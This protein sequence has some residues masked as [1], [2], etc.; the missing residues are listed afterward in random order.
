MDASKS[1]TISRV[2]QLI[3]NGKIKK[4]LKL[5]YAFLDEQGFQEE[6]NEVLLLQSRL[7]TLEEA[8]YRSGENID[9]GR[10]NI[11]AAVLALLEGI[12][13][14][15]LKQPKPVP[16]YS[17]G[18][19]LHNIPRQM[20]LGDYAECKVRI[21]YHKR[22]L[23]KGFTSTPDT[24][25][26]NISKIGRL[27]E[28]T[29]VP[30]GESAFSVMSVSSK[31][32]QVIFPDIYTEWTFYV[33]PLMPGRHTLILDV[34]LMIEENGEQVRREETFREEIEVSAATT[35]QGYWQTDAY[36]YTNRV[37]YQGMSSWMV[38][39]FTFP[40]I[41]QWLIILLFGVSAS[42]G[43]V[44]GHYLINEF[45]FPPTHYYAV[46]KSH[47]FIE[48][49]VYFNNQAITFT[50]DSIHQ[51]VLRV[52][53]V[54]LSSDTLR[55]DTLWVTDT[56]KG[57][58]WI[59]WG[60]IQDTSKII[61]L[62]LYG[63]SPDSV[64]NTPSGDEPRS[65]SSPILPSDCQT[66][67][68]IEK[69]T[70]METNIF[71]DDNNEIKAQRIGKG[72]YRVRICDFTNVHNLKYVVDIDSL[73]YHYKWVCSY[74]IEYKIIGDT[75][76]FDCWKSPIVYNEDPNRPLYPEI[77]VNLPEGIQDPI[78][79]V[80]DIPEG[81]WTYDTVRGC[82]VFAYR[83]ED[84]KSVKVSG[85]LMG[86]KYKCE[87]K[88]PF[89]HVVE[90]TVIIEMDCKPP[91]RPNPTITVKLPPGIKI[92]RPYTATLNG[93][94]VQPRITG[95]DIRLTVPAGKK[96]IDFRIEDDCYV[97]RAFG[98][99]EQITLEAH[100]DAKGV[101]IVMEPDPALKGFCSR[102]KILVDGNMNPPFVETVK[103]DFPDF[104]IL[105]D[106]SKS[107]SLVLEVADDAGRVRQFVL[108]QLL[109]S[110][111]E[112]GVKRWICKPADLP[113]NFRLLDSQ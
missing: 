75:L 18:L 55:P 63:I 77:Q 7:A 65:D 50:Q 40:Q 54:P 4:A 1:K 81:T 92:S 31:P 48:P 97:C 106:R 101:K 113:P 11:T 38:L 6:K 19:L 69:A 105:S 53:L 71:V 44:I 59:F 3:A 60:K 87:K 61:D 103:P 82:L 36:V 24:A 104:K 23:L 17:K 42:V 110:K 90:N 112:C 16:I 79:E 22:A 37:M 20:K 39:A 68:K 111:G 78:L 93:K 35:S 41:Y 109:V 9:T 83:I 12:G 66:F 89:N 10:N 64:Q 32:R 57:T 51:N 56:A 76:R 100:C 2:Q 108:S 88:P 73:G 67:L 8:H 46:A 74:T 70:E 5:L 58:C 95:T 52:E 102:M 62:K 98:T 14:E 47:H 25:I 43:G 15:E 85:T 94:S 96:E 29:L 30:L 28:V 27:M 72:L 21:A 13:T 80:P 34:A 45:F 86:K 26:R 91:R 49:V 84:L 99:P 33:K 107:V